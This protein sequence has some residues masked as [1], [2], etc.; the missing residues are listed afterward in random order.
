[1]NKFIKITLTAILA[2]TLTACGE[3]PMTKE[4]AF[5]FYSDALTNTAKA[6]SY[7]SNVEMSYLISDGENEIKMGIGMNLILEG[8][9]TNNPKAMM[10]V[11]TQM[12]GMD[13]AAEMYYADGYIYTNTLGEKTKTKDSIDTL[14][15]FKNTA[16]NIK[17]FE[18]IKVTKKDGITTLEFKMSNDQLNQ[19]LGESMNDT[20][21]IDAMKYTDTNIVVTVNPDNTIKD[22][23]ISLVAT[24]SVEAQEANINV[25]IT[26][27][28]TDYNTAKVTLP[29]DLDSYTL[30]Y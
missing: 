2:L 25:D 27:S 12:F 19:M 9:T 6:D 29:A 8:Q 17:D 15:Q 14:E 20:L 28:Y 30:M 5:Q 26:M 18:D 10:L 13:I 3:K 22:M 24:M 23:I 11:E 16:I 7:N 4:E 1:M 21:G